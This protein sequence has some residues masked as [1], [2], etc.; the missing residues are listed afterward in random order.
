MATPQSHAPPPGC[1]HGHRLRFVLA[2][3]ARTAD[4]L[5]FF[6]LAAADAPTVLIH[7][8]VREL[9]LR[10]QQPM[11]S[12]AVKTFVGDFLRGAGGGTA[13]TSAGARSAKDE[14]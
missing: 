13:R 10:L 3:P 7:D 12:E 6:G 8:T 1:R 5:K 14:V 9:K 11:G 4:F 2:D